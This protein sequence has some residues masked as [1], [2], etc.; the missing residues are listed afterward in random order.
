MLGHDFASVL[1]RFHL[2]RSEVAGGAARGIFTLLLKRSG[3]SW[4][5]ILDHTS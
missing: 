5:I 1:G 3:E 4:T 2:E